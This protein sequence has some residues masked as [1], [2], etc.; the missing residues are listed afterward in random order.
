MRRISEKK[1]QQIKEE[2]PIRIA[3]CLRAEGTWEKASE[4]SGL[5]IGGKCELCHEQPDFRGLRPHEQLFRS[6]GGVLSLDNSI[7][8]C[9][10]CHSLKHG[11][12][13]ADCH[14]GIHG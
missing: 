3:L 1:R 10:R 9:G 11:I 12:H 7:M 4:F 14:R 13:E 6:K 2:Y 8:L 5:C